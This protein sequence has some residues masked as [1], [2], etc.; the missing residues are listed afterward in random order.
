MLISTYIMSMI[1]S[2]TITIVASDSWSVSSSVLLHNFSHSW[3]PTNWTLVFQSLQLCLLEP[4][5]ILFGNPKLSLD[6]VPLKQVSTVWYLGVYIDQHLT[7]HN[8][9]EYVLRRVRGK[10]YSLNRLKPLTP[11]VM[12][13][14]YQAHVLPIVDYCDVVW[15][16]TNVSHLKRLERLHSHFLSFDSTSSV[17]NFTLAECRRFHTAVQ[18]YWILN[19]LSPP[20]LHPTFRYAVSVTGHTGCNVHQLYVPAVHL[21]Y[22]KR[23]LYYQSACLSHWNWFIK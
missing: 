2:W 12:K 3:L 9:M 16:P 6:N 4:D 5:N 17:L 21:N 18:V 8:H 19:K 22:G 14:L 10:L 7:W 15:V 11:T 1:L 20:Y 23:S 13:L